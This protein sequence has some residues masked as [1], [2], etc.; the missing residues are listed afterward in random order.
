MPSRHRIL[1]KPFPAPSA[2]HLVICV[3]SGSQPPGLSVCAQLS[4][5]PLQRF[6]NIQLNNIKTLRGRIVNPLSLNILYDVSAK[7]KNCEAMEQSGY[8]SEWQK[9]L[10]PLTSLYYILFPKPAAYRFKVEQ[11]ILVPS[12]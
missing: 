6:K 9:V 10:L 8:I 1:G 2:V 12:V 11:N 7:S 3:Q 4:L 5:S